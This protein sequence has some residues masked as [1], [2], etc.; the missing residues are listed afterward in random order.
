M[1][2]R[3]I[4]LVPWR[5]WVISASRVQ[6]STSASARNGKADGCPCCELFEL[7]EDKI[8]RFYCYPERSVIFA[9][10]GVLTNREAALTR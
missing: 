1:S 6:R 10:L 2:S 4:W 9:Q 3:R 8:K 7:E 5:F